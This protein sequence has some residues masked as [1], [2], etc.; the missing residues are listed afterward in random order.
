MNKIDESILAL[1]GFALR[2]IL[3][4]EY[5]KLFGYKSRPKR[6][7]LFKRFVDDK[8][9][10]KETFIEKELLILSI[11]DVVKAIKTSNL[12][13]DEQ[14]IYLTGVL[15]GLFSPLHESDFFKKDD[16]FLEFVKHGLIDYQQDDILSTLPKRAKRSLDQD[17]MKS[18]L[19]G[20]LLLTAISPDQLTNGF[21]LDRNK[22]QHY[23]TKIDSNERLSFSLGQ[24]KI[25]SYTKAASQMI[26]I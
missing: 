21:T 13:E 7:K 1:T 10:T 8:K 22:L 2:S 26:N 15:S 3:D 4:N 17:Q 12:S 23:L 20:V 24:D 14:I 9:L 18:I 25:S 16:D 19:S 5:W 6:G 11:I